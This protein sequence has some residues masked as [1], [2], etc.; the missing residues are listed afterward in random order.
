MKCRSQVSPLWKN[1]AAN[2]PWY[3][4]L[5]EPGHPRPQPRLH[6]TGEVD[7]RDRG[8]QQ[9]DQ[10][11]RDASAPAAEVIRTSPAE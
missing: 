5:V 1:P 3:Q 10:H 2:G 8:D 6:P 9:R 7:D 4:V 11:R